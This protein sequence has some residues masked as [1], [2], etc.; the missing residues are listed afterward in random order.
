MCVFVLGV[1]PNRY[2][3]SVHQQ[4]MCT[5]ILTGSCFSSYTLPHWK[6]AEVEFLSWDW[7]HSVIV[8][9]RDVTIQEQYRF[10]CCSI[11]WGIL[12]WHCRNLAVY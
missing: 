1:V 10:N 7:G 2:Y 4:V 9:F 3:I 6:L 5:A 11:T 8:K 12:Y